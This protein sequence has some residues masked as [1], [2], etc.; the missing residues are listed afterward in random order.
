MSEILGLGRYSYRKGRKGQ[1][2]FA[3]YAEKIFSSENVEVW[4]NPYNHKGVDIVVKD[5]NDKPIRVMEVTNYA[6]HV[7]MSRTKAQHYIDSLKVWRSI[8][9][10][11]YLAI[12]ISYPFTVDHIKGVRKMFVDERIE[13]WVWKG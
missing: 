6:P 2:A 9:P 1:N 7:W 13:V 11:I 3:E 8:Y 10:D 4:N 5:S 12:V